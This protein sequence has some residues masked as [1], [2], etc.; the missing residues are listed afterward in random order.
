MCS[1][2]LASLL[3]EMLDFMNVVPSRYVPLIFTLI[4]SGIGQLQPSGHFVMMLK[5][6]SEI[7]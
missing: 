2:S 5:I 3:K 7:Q 1:F 4:F 6:N